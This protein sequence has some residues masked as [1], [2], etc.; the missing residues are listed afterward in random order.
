MSSTAR[1]QAHGAA[2]KEQGVGGSRPA[3]GEP[4]ARLPGQDGARAEDV[5]Y[6]TR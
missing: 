2:Q 4:G 1:P 5:P 6:S 3:P